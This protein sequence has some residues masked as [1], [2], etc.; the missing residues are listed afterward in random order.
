MPIAQDVDLNYLASIT[1][2]FVGADL[3]ALCREAAMNSVR[4]LMPQLTVDTDDLLDDAL[5]RLDVKMSHFLE[6]MREL[7]P[8]AIREVLVETPN[9]RWQDIGGLGPVKQ[10]LR[11]SIDWPLR[12]PHLFAEA[13]VKPPRGILLAGAPGTGKTTLAKALARESEANFISIKGPALFS[14]WVGETEKGVREIFRKARQVAPT[15]IFIDE[16]D[17]LAPAR[18]RATGDSGV[19]DR[20]IS[21]LL[22]EMDGL[23]ELKGVVVV[24]ATNRKDMLDAA[25]LRPGRFDLVLELPVPDDSE[26]LE[27]LEIHAR[28][29]PF[30]ADVNLRQLCGELAGWVGADI[31]LLVNRASILAIRQYV[32]SGETGTLTISR[33]HLRQAISLGTRHRQEKESL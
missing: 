28:G 26:R 3:A 25:L 5:A 10:V 6:A 11:E 22:T 23:E 2:G 32:D 19:A 9:V 21:Q 16:I 13:K 4:A 8:S 18:G 24:A 14:K 15:I 31:E 12:Y 1:H 7:E 20:V 17:A 33:E 27:I 30:A 29:R